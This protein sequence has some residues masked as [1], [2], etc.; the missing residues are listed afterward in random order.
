M[1]QEFSDYE[2]LVNISGFLIN[3]ELLPFWM[4]FEFIGEAVPQLILAMVFMANN[5]EYMKEKGNIIG[6]KEFYQTLISI[7]FSIGSIAIGLYSAIM[8]LV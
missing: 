6:V 8:P 3:S 5:S 4:G 7:I 2:D 1:R